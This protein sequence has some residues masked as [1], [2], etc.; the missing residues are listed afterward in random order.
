MMLTIPDDLWCWPYIKYLSLIYACALKT[1]YLV[2]KV[3]RCSIPT[4]ICVLLMLV[5]GCMLVRVSVT[6]SP[7]SGNAWAAY[8]HSLRW[9]RLH[10]FNPNITALAF[11]ELVKSYVKH[12]YLYLDIC[13]D[14]DITH[15]TTDVKKEWSISPSILQ[16]F[17][18]ELRILKVSESLCMQPRLY[19][20][21]LVCTLPLMYDV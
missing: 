3:K 11:G 21:F 5:T 17:T 6:R 4:W 12:I 8:W 20:W 7:N 13:F 1:S 2:L 9:V 18:S 16:E 19:D 14:S 15:V 10:I